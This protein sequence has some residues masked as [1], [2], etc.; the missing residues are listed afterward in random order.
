[1]VVIGDRWW[2]TSR[3]GWR[4]TIIV[5]EDTWFLALRR[6]GTLRRVLLLKHT[7]IGWRLSF[8]VW[9]GFF[10]RLFERFLRS[11]FFGSLAGRTASLKH[12]PNGAVASAFLNLT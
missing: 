1:M 6:L 11:F 3:S 7:R 8:D 2:S 10:G 9:R 4:L 5:V 12:T